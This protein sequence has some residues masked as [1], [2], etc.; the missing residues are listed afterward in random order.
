MPTLEAKL[1][2]VLKAL[3]SI[4]TNPDPKDVRQLQGDLRAALSAVPAPDY[5]ASID[6]RNSQSLLCRSDDDPHRLANGATVHVQSHPLQPQRPAD[7]AFV[8]LLTY[9]PGSTRMAIYNACAADCPLLWIGGLTMTD[10]GRVVCAQ[11][12]NAGQGNSDAYSYWIP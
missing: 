3:G 7:P 10:D 5:A 4:A 1:D 8:D 2:G 9:S 11:V 12:G 6:A